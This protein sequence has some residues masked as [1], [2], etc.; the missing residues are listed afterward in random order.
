MAPAEFLTDPLHDPGVVLGP[1][2]YI[3]N[4]FVR[5]VLSQDQFQGGVAIDLPD[6][7]R[8]QD[9]QRD[10]S[11]RRRLE[12]PAG[13]HGQ[14]LEE[15]PV[16]HRVE[17]RPAHRGWNLGIGD[18]RHG[19]DVEFPQVFAIDVVVGL[20]LLPLGP[21]RRIVPALADQGD[22]AHALAHRLHGLQHPRHATPAALGVADIDHAEFLGGEVER[23]LPG[24]I[25]DMEQERPDVRPTRPQRRLA[26]L[27]GQAVAENDPLA[28]RFLGAVIVVAEEQDRIV[29]GAVAIDHDATAARHRRQQARPVQPV[30]ELQLRRPFDDEDDGV[31]A[32]QVLRVVRRLRVRQTVDRHLMA[33]CL[34]RPGVAAQIQHAAGVL[35]SPVDEHQ[36]HRVSV[37]AFSPAVQ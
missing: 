31:G 23:R 26:D 14:A 37:S 35:V 22:T 7:G 15:R 1:G 3:K 9:G 25:V 4:L 11:G 2:Q 6:I 29:V 30:A 21:F 10:R 18:R 13:D 28:A 33:H 8:I 20:D 19:L 17:D 12:R 24:R 32:A 34:R 36:L 5:P 16:H 27:V